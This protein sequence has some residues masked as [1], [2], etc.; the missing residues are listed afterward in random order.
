ML[1]AVTTLRAPHRPRTCHGPAQPGAGRRRR[2]RGKNRRP[3]FW[4]PMLVSITPPVTITVEFFPSWWTGHGIPPSLRHVLSTEPEPPGARQCLTGGPGS[5]QSAGRDLRLPELAIPVR[6]YTY[7]SEVATAFDG[8]GC[9]PSR[10]ADRSAG[11]TSWVRVSSAVHSVA[12]RPVIQPGSCT[13]TTTASNRRRFYWGRRC[14]SRP[15]QTSSLSLAMGLNTILTTI[16]GLSTE[17]PQSPKP[18]SVR[19]IGRPRTVSD[20]L[21]MSGGQGVAS[22][23]LASPTKPID[24]IRLSRIGIQPTVLPPSI[25]PSDGRSGPPGRKRC[26]SLQ[27]GLHIG[28]Q[29]ASRNCRIL[30]SGDPLQGVHRRQRRPSRSGRCAVGRGGPGPV[31]PAR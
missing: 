12:P 2:R 29:V 17:I 7:H 11:R 18:L 22:S 26:A 8:V 15:D 5:R 6:R 25:T 9:T 23:N 30:M 27:H 1:N 31:A 3:T 14:S 21:P 10:S 13:Q 19:E 16:L 4:N 24:A 28:M 20:T